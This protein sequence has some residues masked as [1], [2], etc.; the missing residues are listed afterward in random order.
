MSVHS[1]EEMS[2]Y[3]F[4]RDADGLEASG[5]NYVLTLTMMG[6]PGD[7]GAQVGCLQCPLP[8]CDNPRTSG[9]CLGA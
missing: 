4:L 7:T 1:A 3:W 9:H 8:L 2:V 6:R 5:K